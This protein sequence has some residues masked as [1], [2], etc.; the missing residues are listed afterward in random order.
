[1]ANQTPVA[2]TVL[3]K[4]GRSPM[5]ACSLSGEVS[6][7]FYEQKYKHKHCFRPRLKRSRGSRFCVM[8]I[9]LVQRQEWTIHHAEYRT[10]VAH[11]WSQYS[12]GHASCKIA[13]LKKCR[14]KLQ[15][16]ACETGQ[17]LQSEHGYRSER[18]GR[19]S[20]NRPGPDGCHC[21]WSVIMSNVD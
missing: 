13:L 14:C 2:T 20:R 12:F 4:I 9:N 5:T 15:I 18:D 8:V 1:M 17:C 11:A 16:R 10:D 19:D 7:G 6:F 3:P 21:C